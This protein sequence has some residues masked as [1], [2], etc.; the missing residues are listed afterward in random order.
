MTWR[1]EI[2][3]Q[4]AFLYCPHSLKQFSFF[5]IFEPNNCPP[6]GSYKMENKCENSKE[7]KG[8]SRPFFLGKKAP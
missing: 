8:L 2:S 3:Y 7:N 1:T 6:I 5:L 4:E